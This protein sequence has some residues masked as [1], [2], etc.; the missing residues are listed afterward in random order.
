MDHL[1]E[2]LNEL[3]QREP[4]PLPE[5]FERAVVD[6]WFNKQS[7]KKEYIILKY[8]VAA[9][10]VGLTCINILALREYKEPTEISTQ[11][12]TD[13]ASENAFAEEYGLIE[14]HTYYSFN[15]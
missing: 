9:C 13:T 8:A 7:K 14:K 3:N 10:I 11:L 15:Q 1:N 4:A 12:T 2:L 5:G 6:K